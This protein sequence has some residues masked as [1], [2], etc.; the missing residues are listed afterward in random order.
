MQLYNILIIRTINWLIYSTT[1]NKENK[2]LIPLFMT[3]RGYGPTFLKFGTL[4]LV[5]AWAS[6]SALSVSYN[7]FKPDC[8]F[9]V[10]FFYVHL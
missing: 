10:H 8:D 5:I 6:F 9:L 1:A 4:L 7:N 3:D 2:T